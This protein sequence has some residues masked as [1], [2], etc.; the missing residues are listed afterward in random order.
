MENFNKFV[1]KYGFSSDKELVEALMAHTFKFTVCTPKA[2]AVLLARAEEYDLNP[3]KGEIYPILVTNGERSIESTRIGYDG[4]LKI[5]QGCEYTFEYAENNVE[6]EFAG[7]T[8]RGPEWV[9]CTITVDSLKYSHRE[10]LDDIVGDTTDMTFL[11]AKRRLPRV[12]FGAVCRMAFKKQEQTVALPVLEKV[13]S[14]VWD[15]YVPVEITIDKEKSKGKS[16]GSVE[17]KESTSSDQNPD[18]ASMPEEEV[19]SLEASEAVNETDH[20]ENTGSGEEGLQDESTKSKE[21]ILQDVVA[22]SEEEILQDVVAESEEEI[23][24]DVVAE[25]EEEILQD[26]VAESEEEILQG[27]APE[28][29]EEILQ[30]EAPELEEEILQGEAPESE[31]EVLQGE[32]P[33]SEEEIL[34]G[35]APESEEEILQGEAPESEEEILQGEVF[36][37]DDQNLKAS[38]TSQLD[39]EE[40]EFD[41]L[42]SNIDEKQEIED[43][44]LID[45]QESQKCESELPA[46]PGALVDGYNS[47]VTAIELNQFETS[48]ATQVLAKIKQNH[49]QDAVKLFKQHVEFSTG[50]QFLDL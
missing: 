50:Y 34:Q 49:G 23:L 19:K 40:V 1:E 29:E 36:E 33:E 5:A 9:T 48:I 11:P 3:F 35:E 44:E 42:N 26:V 7:E 21:E 12:A 25:S 31:E 15:S 41:V 37:S 20:R 4:W 14:S 32:A 6:I 46:L 27:E 8:V 30:G 17:I 22:E 10:Y 24:Q 38:G 13:T 18:V 47:V 39:F 45:N 2:V 28:S 16:E 43:A